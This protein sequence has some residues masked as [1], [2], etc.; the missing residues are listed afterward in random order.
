MIHYPLKLLKLLA[1]FASI[2]IPLTPHLTAGTTAFQSE[3][4]VDTAT[5]R[6]DASGNFN[7]LGFPYLS[8]T[9][10][11]FLNGV[12]SI[13]FV[14]DGG[15]PT[16]IVSSS[17]PRPNGGGSV[18]GL[19]KD[20]LTIIG[21]TTVFAHSQG[22]FQET[23]GA[24]TFLADLSTNA[25]GF[26]PAAPFYSFN[27][28][29]MTASQVAFHGLVDTTPSRTSGVFVLDRSS[30]VISLVAAQGDT[31][32]T[33]GGGTFS[34]LG[35]PA[36][37]SV[38]VAFWGANGSVNSGIFLQEASSG[39]LLSIASV[40]DRTKTPDDR[41][42]TAFGQEVAVSEDGVYFS[43]TTFSGN[44]LYYHDTTSGEISIITDPLNQLPG[45][46]NAVFN[47]A[48]TAD[49][50]DLLVRVQQGSDFPILFY[51]GDGS[52]GGGFSRVL[53]KD[54]LLDGKIVTHAFIADR[55]ALLGD[56]C[57]VRVY[58][59]DGS[60]GIYAFEASA[61][62]S[63]VTV[64]SS[65][66]T[67]GATVT[68][69]VTLQ[70]MGTELA[71]SGSLEFDP[72]VFSNPQLSLGANAASATLT[73]NLGEVSQGRV[74]FL[75]G[76]PFG[77][78]FAPGSAEILTLQLDVASNAP[79][80]AYPIALTDT[81]TIREI[82][83]ELAE[84]LTASWQAGTVTIANQDPTPANDTAST[85]ED[86]ALNVAAPGVLSNDLDPDTSDT[87][88]V[89]SQRI[90]TAN[91][92]SFDLD[93][94]GSYAYD[95]TVSSA[96]NALAESEQLTETITYTVN[97][98]NGGSATATLEITVNGVNDAPTATNDNGGST[99]ANVVL[100]GSG[101]LDNDTDPDATD[102]LQVS[103]A[104]SASAQGAVV[105]VNADG[106][107][108]FDPTGATALI[109]LPAG[110]SVTDT[111]SYTAADPFG[112]TSAAQVTVTV[113]GVND[114][115]VAGDDTATTF[116]DA[117]VVIAD[118]LLNDSDPDTGDSI[119]F[120]EHNASSVQGATISYEERDGF[121]Y[122]PTTS[123][124]LAALTDGETLTDTFTYTIEDTNGATATATISVSVTGIE[125]EGD[126]TPRPNG[127]DAVDVTDAVLIANMVVG[128]ETAAGT[129]FTRADIAPRAD[130]GN[131][132]LSAADWVQA[133]RYAAGL[134]PAT[135]ISGPTSPL[136]LAQHAE[137]APLD[138][139]PL[140]SAKLTVAQSGV[141]T[142]GRIRLPIR[143]QSSGQVAAAGFSLAFD[144]AAVRYVGNYPAIAG[145][146]AATLVNAQQAEAGRLG[147]VIAQS[148]V[149]KTFPADEIT[150]VELEFETVG[151]RSGEIDE[152]AIQ[153][154][155][156]PA[157]LALSNVVA[158]QVETEYVGTTL[159]LSAPIDQ[160]PA[161]WLG[162]Y[163]P[164]EELADPDKEATFWG[165]EADPD[166]DG[167]TNASEYL[168]GT[169]PTDA[170]SSLV[171]AIS[172][173]TGADT[174]TIA[175][176]PARRDR[177]YRLL[178]QTDLRDPFLPIG[179]S[180]T[181]FHLDA[182]GNGTFTNVPHQGERGFYRVQ[183]QLPSNNEAETP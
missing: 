160:L 123:P 47:G 83:D 89:V 135:R 127:D 71:V 39:N 90:T 8:S 92:A 9:G 125:Y 76:L 124:A 103:T 80:G 28:P 107:F 108:S 179:S 146:E 44:G 96:C 167:F 78:P 74:G 57:V 38:G 99:N 31:M 13:Y 153:F 24:D 106:S 53:G 141:D 43:G 67:R 56:R 154:A 84:S 61:N 51:D 181:A 133:L 161:E 3:K 163:F 101:L 95:P 162:R 91:G 33:V 156:A 112:G 114:A 126:V 5:P 137:A 14:P 157:R 118:F 134:D 69:P 164:A 93:P 37:S 149:G 10:I 42:F 104:D 18:Y 177:V 113:T 45:T 159:R 16:T 34:S 32:P 81:P 22:L 35:Y 111:F 182:E 66:G 64:G 140:G 48:I 132:W 88:T 166:G 131:G 143:M 94:D 171:A 59:N 150:L 85:D 82:T 115:P 75:L 11:T 116:Q 77:S 63:T 122:D 55:N 173:I 97:D 158:E 21:G 109:S 176:A 26:D 145:N 50:S 58:F 168:A 4:I 40:G 27:G 98:D 87:L 68:L 180:E 152:T 72:A 25:P 54:D 128:N 130:G 105:N 119:S 175:F 79:L 120:K 23:G 155:S 17:D 60:K 138:V 151:L 20:E 174:L 117:A 121:T 6:P 170:Q 178:Y 46:E 139:A 73:Q 29:A 1:L 136:I 62:T 15:T 147:I 7:N 102:T 2:S 70:A 110:Q 183:V 65:P 144:P 36:V 142:A 86:T 12:G 30:G 169:S 19:I 172:H 52:A 129:E 165:A 148:S 49:G 100:I 41:Q